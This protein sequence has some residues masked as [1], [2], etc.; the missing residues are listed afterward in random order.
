VGFEPG[1]SYTKGE[2]LNRWPPALYDNDM[3]IRLYSW[4]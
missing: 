2:I 4:T 1:T 3:L